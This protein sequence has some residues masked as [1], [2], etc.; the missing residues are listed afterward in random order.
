TIKK[1]PLLAVLGKNLR[2]TTLAT[3]FVVSLALLGTVTACAPRIDTRGNAVLIK[4]VATIEP[5]TRTRDHVLNTLGSPSSRSTFGD[6][7]WYYISERTETTAFLAPEI[8]ER[9]IIVVKFDEYGVVSNVD[10]YDKDS[11]EAVEPVDRKTPT[12]GN[13]LGLVEQLLSN[14]GRFN[15]K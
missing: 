14:I 6:N 3:A 1:A 11:A 2:S 7:A 13:Q 4:D 9:Q 5:G 8:I 12:A 15:K 10:V